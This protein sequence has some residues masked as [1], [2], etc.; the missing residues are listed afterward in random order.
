MTGHARDRPPARS[1]RTCSSR[2]AGRPATPGIDVADRA[3]GRGLERARRVAASSAADDDATFERE[4][5]GPDRRAGIPRRSALPAGSAAAI[6]RRLDGRPPGP[7]RP[8]PARP[9]RRS[10]ATSGRKALEIPRGEVRPYGWIAA[11]IG[12]PKAVRAVGTALGHNPVP[13]IV[14]CHRVVRTR[15][16]D[17][18]VLARRART[19]SGR[20]SPPKASILTRS[21]AHGRGPAIRLH[22][23]RHDPDR[24]PADRACHAAPGHR[25]A[26]GVPFRSLGGRGRAG[27]PA[28]PDLPASAA[29]GASPPEVRR[30]GRTAD[31]LRSRTTAVSW[32]SR[33]MPTRSPAARRTR[34]AD[35]LAGHAR[36]STSCGARRT[37]GSRS[38]STR[39]RRSSWP[40]PR[41][42]IA[43]AILLAWSIA[44]SGRS[45]ALPSSARVAR[46]RD[47]RRRCCSAAGW[48]WS[49]SASR[50]SRRGSPRCSSR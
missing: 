44:A 8:R 27:L 1:P 49:R 28:V 13:L 35:D 45:F 6:A 43:G 18:P 46:Q 16:H 25:P 3:A 40:R 23:L 31:G 14:P 24:V 5:R 34:R 10:S 22:R 29:G 38:R 12:R 30:R 4:P 20:S 26:I 32:T 21:E 33:L 47:R 17:R 15:R 2:S 50:P 39:S 36:S 42:L 7:H 41:F 48:A 9:H 37:S 19:T 11:E